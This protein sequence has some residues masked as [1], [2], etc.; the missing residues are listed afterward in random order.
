ML[1]T[2]IIPPKPVFAFEGTP[3]E[4]FIHR[5]EA[6]CSIRTHMAGLHVSLRYVS[7]QWSKTQIEFNDVL[8]LRTTPSSV[9]A[10]TPNIKR[11]LDTSGGNTYTCSTHF[12]PPG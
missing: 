5:R 2:S 4:T 11:S 10:A 8:L 3:V 1:I 9:V 12:N 6:T 7:A